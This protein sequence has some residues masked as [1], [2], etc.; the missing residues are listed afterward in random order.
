MIERKSRFGP[1]RETLS[2][3]RS[4]RSVPTSRGPLSRPALLGLRTVPGGTVLGCVGVRCPRP[5]S[6]RSGGRLFG[7]SRV[8]DPRVASIGT[9]PCDRSCRNDP[10]P[11]R[12]CFPQPVRPVRNRLPERRFRVVRYLAFP[13]SLRSGSG[14]G[15][16]PVARR[17]R[18]R[19]TGA[20]VLAPHRF[21]HALRAGAG[22][23]VGPRDPRGR[24]GRTAREIN[25]VG[26]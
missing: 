23:P 6:A 18:S 7:G 1:G 19:V 17:P 5:C 21:R 12:S 26:V 4:T 24:Q 25:L 15:R 9:W 13:P 3:T 20:S 2:S 14:S 11:V 22:R 10:G 8:P 16:F